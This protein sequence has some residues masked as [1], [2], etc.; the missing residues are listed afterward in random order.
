[1]TIWAAASGP[2]WGVWVKIGYGVVERKGWSCHKNCQKYV[3]DAD[4]GDNIRSVEE[5]L[6]RGLLW[7]FFGPCWGRI[8]KICFG[9]LG[10]EHM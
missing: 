7:R 6:A 4:H 1:M 3:V 9:H 5:N 2:L 10:E 8:K